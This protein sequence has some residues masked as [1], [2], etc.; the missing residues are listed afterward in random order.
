MKKKKDCQSVNEIKS[1]FENF[2]FPGSIEMLIFFPLIIFP[3]VRNFRLKRIDYKGFW[4]TQALKLPLVQKAF[5]SGYV[6]A[7]PFIK[8]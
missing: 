4:W 8:S 3:P 7:A 6:G 2:S 5:S 1:G